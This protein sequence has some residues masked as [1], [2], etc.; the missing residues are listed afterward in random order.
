MVSMGHLSLTVGT[1]ES[2]EA[3]NNEFTMP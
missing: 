1:G 2:S 3:L